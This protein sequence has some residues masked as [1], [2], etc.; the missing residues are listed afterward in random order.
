MRLWCK[1]KE[2]TIQIFFPDCCKKATISLHY[3]NDL[4]KKS[5]PFLASRTLPKKLGMWFVVGY[6]LIF[7]TGLN[8]K[9]M[10]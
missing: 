7:D 4:D 6:V 3:I 5:A 8:L 2:L 1:M 10:H 9:Q